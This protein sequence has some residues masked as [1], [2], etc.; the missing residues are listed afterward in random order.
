MTDGPTPLTLSPEHFWQG[1]PEDLEQGR[2]EGTLSLSICPSSRYE[3]SKEIQMFK[4]LYRNIQGS[5]GAV[6]SEV[7]EE[8]L[9]E[10]LK[11]VPDLW[12]CPKVMEHLSVP[13]VNV[14]Y[15]TQKAFRKS[16]LLSLVF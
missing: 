7:R 6:R 1:Y 10:T 11:G 4:S 9:G 16:H 2:R 12:D 15:R 14:P 13:C 8:T 3:S 5:L